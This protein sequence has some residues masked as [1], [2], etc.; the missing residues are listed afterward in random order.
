MTRPD[1]LHGLEIPY[2]KSVDELVKLTKETA[3][4]CW[5]AYT[6]LGFHNSDKSIEALTSL[7]ANQDWTHKRSAIEAIGNNE[8]GLRLESQ[9]IDSLND[10]NKFVVSA[11]IKSL[12]NLGSKKAHDKIKSLIG[13]ENV[14][15]QHAA[16][17]GLSG[18]FEQN[19]FNF[20]IDF[21]K[22]S[23]KESTRKKIGFVLA[24]HIDESNWKMF[25]DTFSK[26]SIIRHREWALTS[27]INFSKDKTFIEKFLTDTDG[28]IRK[29]A[30]RFAGQ[31][32]A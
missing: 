30:K 19:D 16:I 9:L 26:D 14:E 7:L 5:A 12:S 15:I 2:S 31:G 24:I 18:L 6:A 22:V 4:L 1:T 3:P 23:A 32:C 28:H 10:S 21:Y 27:A 8:N 17:E 11:A 20:L 29:M 25:F 13:S